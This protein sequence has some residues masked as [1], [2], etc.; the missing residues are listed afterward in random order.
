MPND[1]IVLIC[2]PLDAAIKVVPHSIRDKCSS[3]N[4]IVAIAPTGQRF[5]KA[6][7]EAIILCAFCYVPDPDDAAGKLAAPETEIL[8][9]M[10][11][12]EPN[13]WRNRN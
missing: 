4:S 8:A 5:L 11:T 2:M 7:P 3:C 1:Q 12:A 13:T 9:E 10:A 6:N